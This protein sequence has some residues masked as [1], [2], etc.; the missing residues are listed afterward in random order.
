MHLKKIAIVHHQLDHV[1]DLVRL[2]GVGRN[3]VVECRLHAQRII[4]RSFCGRILHV[5]LRQVAEQ[6]AQH[7]QAVRLGLGYAMA[8]AGNLR[9]RHG[10]AQL[11]K[12]HIF[13][14]DGLHHVGAGDKHVGRVLHHQ[15]EVREGGRVHSTAGTRAHDGA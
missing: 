7:I 11:F 14:R 5:V 2:A 1:A 8:H 3:D 9:V 15:D 10:A 6:H 13:L 4:A 12:S